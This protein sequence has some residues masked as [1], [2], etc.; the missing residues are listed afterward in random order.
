MHGHVLRGRVGL[1]APLVGLGR[2]LLGG[3]RTGLGGHGALLGGRADGFHLG[4]SGGRVGHRLDGLAQSVGDAGDPVG[5]GTQQAQQFR[6][7]HLGH[8]HR[9]YRCR[10]GWP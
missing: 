7:G 1:G 4:F 9:D 6:A 10:Q 3:G 2:T 8:R 5:F